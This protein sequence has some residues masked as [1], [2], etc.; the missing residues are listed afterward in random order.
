[1]A[2]TIGVDDAL[3]TDF[4]R[5]CN[6][7]GLNATTAVNLYMRKVVRDRMIPF[8]LT[9]DGARVD[10]SHKSSAIYSEAINAFDEYD[11]V[12]RELADR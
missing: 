11:D 10:Y 9:A 2:L 6:E 1:M 8:P 3:K 5:V 7:I 4:I 12:F